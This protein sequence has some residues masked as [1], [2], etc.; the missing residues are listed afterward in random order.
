MRKLPLASQAKDLFFNLEGKQL[1]PLISLLFTFFLD[2]LLVEYQER[3]YSQSS[4]DPTGDKVVR[5]FFFFYHPPHL[6]RLATRSLVPST[7]TYVVR[8]E[9][10]WDERSRNKNNKKDQRKRI[11]LVLSSHHHAFLLH[12]E[13]QRARLSSFLPFFLYLID[14]STSHDFLLP[15]QLPSPFW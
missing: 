1:R 5:L 11:P 4:D 15:P 2:W 14:R 12:R 7:H 6:R 3:K 13:K 10:G 8:E 9:I